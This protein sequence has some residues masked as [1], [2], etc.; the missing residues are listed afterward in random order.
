MFFKRSKLLFTAHV[1]GS[2]YAIYLMAHFFGSVG[3]T[4]GAEQVGAGIATALILPHLVLV[5]FSVMFGFLGFFLRKD[6]FNLT[7][8]ILYSVATAAF[9][10]YFFFTVPLVIMSFIGYVKQK[11]MNEDPVTQVQ[12]GT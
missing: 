11:R 8:G 6:G 7:A 10:L 3:A 2:M 9:L 5:I 4:E 1:L 12:T